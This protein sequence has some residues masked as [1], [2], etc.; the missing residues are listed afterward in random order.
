LDGRYLWIVWREILDHPQPKM[1]LI[2]GGQILQGYSAFFA[3]L[4]K[5]CGFW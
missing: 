4:L 2:S 3:K 1:H 5:G